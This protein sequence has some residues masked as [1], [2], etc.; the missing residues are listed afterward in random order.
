MIREGEAL[1]DADD[2]AIKPL[3]AVIMRAAASATPVK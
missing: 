3:I 1:M 2:V